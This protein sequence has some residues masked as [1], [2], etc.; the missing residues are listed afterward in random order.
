[1]GIKEEW[2]KQFENEEIK[3]FVLK[4]EDFLEILSEEEVKLFNSW[5]ERHEQYRINKGKKPFNEYYVVNKDDVPH[6][7]TKEQYFSII[8]YKPL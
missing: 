7:V 1:M 2:L 5:L 6:I 3:F 4:V 8:G